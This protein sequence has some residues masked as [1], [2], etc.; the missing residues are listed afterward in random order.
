[1][2]VTS[3]TSVC[4]SL[5]KCDFDK[6]ISCQDEPRVEVN[7]FIS[8][9]S[10]RESLRKYNEFLVAWGTNGDAT[11]HQSC[12]E[13]ILKAARCRN[14]KRSPYPQMK[15]V[16]KTWVKEAAKTA[17]FFDSL[18][19]IRIEATRIVKLIKQCSHC[20]VFTGA[21][22]STSAGIG[23]YRGKNG[24][25]TKEDQ[26]MENAMQAEIES[27]EDSSL[28]EPPT[29]RVKKQLIKP[30]ETEASTSEEDEVCYEELRPTYTHEAIQKLM[31]LGY[32]KHVISQNCDGL[33]CLSGVPAQALSE[34]HGNVFTEVCE[35]CQKRY[36]RPF[37][38]MDDTAS[39]YYEELADFGE[40]DVVKP[41]HAS[42]CK[43]CGLSHRTGR[44]CM[45]RGCNGY[46]R[47]TI[48]NFRDNLEEDILSRATEQCQK[49]DLMLCLGTTLTV[50]PASNLVQIT[51]HPHRI[52]IC[53]RQKTHMD[54]ECLKT[55]PDGK[56][57]GS[58]VFGDCDVLMRIVMKE[59]MSVAELS[60]WE[61][62]RDDRLAEYAKN[63]SLKVEKT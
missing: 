31:E 42:Q 34:L 16:E 56:A 2:A 29:K 24:K 60:M 61:Q 18:N 15:D 54:K 47:D 6:K 30:E 33:H 52:V 32:I 5:K 23:D 21:G 59:L 63:R 7:T 62:G 3:E 4:C 12:W 40:T 17:E 50:T 36:H 49:R 37:Y 57:L 20:V 58:R 10:A 38:V 9:K 28:T 41:A 35:K 53:N 46:L 48:I 13:S 14:R 1:M 51:G 44:Q 55:G 43:L 8:E 26:R 27:E 25:W 39:A 11:F 22:I 45:Q 19:K